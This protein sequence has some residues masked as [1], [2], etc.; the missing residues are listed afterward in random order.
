MLTRDGRLTYVDPDRAPAPR[1][2]HAPPS[3]PAPYQWGTS[4]RPNVVVLDDGPRNE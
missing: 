4:G 3:D 2:R 1:T